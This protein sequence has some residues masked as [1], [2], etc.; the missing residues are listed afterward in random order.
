MNR[1]PSIS[2]RPG[3]ASASYRRAGDVELSRQGQSQ[4]CAMKL[5]LFRPVAGDGIFPGLLTDR[6]VVNIASIVKPGYTPELT[7][8]GIIDDFERL[9]PGLEDARARG[10]AVP[11]ESVRLMPPLPRP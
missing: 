7:M 3:M 1:A 11:L 5:V 10:E 6:G 2:P 8:E 4:E 9:R